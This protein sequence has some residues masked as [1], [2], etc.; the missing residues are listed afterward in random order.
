M[1][2]P[3][4]MA[5]VTCAQPLHVP[6]IR[7]GNRTQAN[8]HGAPSGTSSDTM[9]VLLEKAT[10]EKYK[11]GDVINADG[12]RPATLFNIAKVATR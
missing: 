6:T 11:A 5:T 7:Y 12:S 1:C 4:D 10:L 8:P 9:R 3:F 2:P